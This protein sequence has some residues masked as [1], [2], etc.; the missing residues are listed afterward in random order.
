[1]SNKHEAPKRVKPKGQSNAGRIF[2]RIRNV[3]LGLILLA[4]VVGT[5]IFA[6]MF[7]AVSKE[8]EDLNIENAALNFSSFIYADDENG[9]SVQ[10]DHLYDESNRIWVDSEEIP[11]RMKDA[12]VSIED[13]RFY[14]HIGF[15][16]KRTSGAFIK[17]T[18]HKFGIGDA[19]Y[20]GSTITQQ[21][22]K[23]ITN[24][25]EKTATRKINE[26]MRAVALERQLSKDEI[27]T[28]YLNI[29]FFA[30]NCYGVQAAS[31]AY[32]DK[33]VSELSLAQTAAIAGITQKPAA[34]DPFKHPDK[35]VEKRNIV[36]SKMLELGYISQ[37][38]Y[39][40]AVAEELVVNKSYQAKKAQISSYFVDQVI[41]DVIN[42]LQTRRGYS[43]NYAKQQLYNGGLRV[44][45]TMDMSIQSIMENVFT[46]TSNF[47]K[48]S[49]QSAM[50]IID[51]YTGQVKGIVG[52]LGKKTESRGLNRATQ[53]Y[54]QPG[55]SI[56]P[57]SVYAAA[58]E[59]GKLTSASV[60]H[61][62][63]VTY[64]SWSPKNSYRGFKGSMLPRKAVEISANIPAVKVLDESGVN[65]AYNFM[66]NTLNFSQ[67]DER[68]IGLSPLA[69]GGLTV[70][71]SPKEM[72]AAYGIFVNGGK[73]ITPYTY[74]KVVDESGKVL[75]ENEAKGTQAISAENAFIV[76]DLLSEVVN[77]T[78]G[79]G[80]AAKL[81][82]MPT[83][84]KTGTTNDDKDRWFVGFT[85]Y[86]VGAVW[87]G[88]DQPKSI[89]S[90]GVSYNPSTRVW[91]TVM[92]QVHKNLAVKEI[93]MPSDIV[94]EEICSYSGMKAKSGCSAHIE[95][96]A[97]GTQPKS[98]CHSSHS[99]K[100]ET[101][102]ED[103]DIH[104]SENAEAN[105]ELNNS[106]ENNT[107]TEHTASPSPTSTKE[108]QKSTPS[109]IDIDDAPAPTKRPAA[110]NEPA[111][112]SPTPEVIDLG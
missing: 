88:F 70:G 96:F 87:Y 45:T 49:A 23:N 82:K 64:G 21:L 97:K 109:P 104:N 106:S 18:L 80:R 27:L 89:K 37:S 11:K 67:I 94:S 51:P 99:G 31:N 59:N 78:A 19:S 85:P 111:K 56:K 40:S 81:S 76:S 38:E 20:G 68:D 65:Y 7:V 74:T 39:D 55:S 66:K 71:A 5:G 79:T 63:E 15:D 91:K 16:F 83:Y 33:D 24:E 90:A 13:E 105:E 93:S 107:A 6:G 103:E 98:L 69:L 10:I 1:M 112:S 54:R 100:A 95:Y 73:Y 32:F 42:D 8:M 75:L 61:D 41:N 77:G 29:V 34:F 25:S 101:S 35:T 17:W 30:N 46:D 4:A 14:K 72:A 102:E 3:I 58:Y 110:T 53:A 43:E 44:Y 47:P 62:E 2:R 86:Y 60:I 57:L 108:P 28:M 26:I 12:V 92:E 52:G 50:I 22:I 84:G 48:V 9:N 36:L